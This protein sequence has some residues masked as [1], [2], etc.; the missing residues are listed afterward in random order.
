MS[1]V[2]QQSSQV[3]RVQ[4]GVARAGEQQQATAEAEAARERARAKSQVQSTEN[5]DAQNRIKADDQ[6]QGRQQQQQAKD[7]AKEREALETRSQPLKPT[8]RGLVDVVV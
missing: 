5:S 7:D 8:S 3:T 1:V 2:L 6:G 4:E